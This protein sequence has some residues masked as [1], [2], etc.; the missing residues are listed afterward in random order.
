[1]EIL[2]GSFKELNYLGDR[3]NISQ[4]KTTLSSSSSLIV[5]IV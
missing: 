3:I 2:K 4:N 5:F 1:M